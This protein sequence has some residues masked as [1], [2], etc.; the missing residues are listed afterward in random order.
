MPTELGLRFF[1]DAMLE[2]GDVATDERAAIEAQVKAA[3]RDQTWEGV[4]TEATSLLSGLTRGAGVV[5][6]L[7]HI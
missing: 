7:I 3:S 1:V 4:L 2:V 5:L 6:S